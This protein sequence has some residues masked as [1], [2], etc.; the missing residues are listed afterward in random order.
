MKNFTIQLDI[1]GLNE[2]LTALDLRRQ[3]L[4]IISQDITAQAQAQMKEEQ[5]NGNGADQQQQQPS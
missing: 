5:A 2:V 1:I 3:L 4:Q